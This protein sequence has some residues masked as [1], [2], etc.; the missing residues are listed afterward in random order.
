MYILC[1]LFDYTSKNIISCI[2]DLWCIAEPNVFFYSYG[3]IL[4]SFGLINGTLIQGLQ[5]DS[6][7][8]TTL[9]NLKDEKP[10]GKPDPDPNNGSVIPTSNKS[11]IKQQANIGSLSST[12]SRELAV[13]EGVQPTDISKSDNVSSIIASNI[14]NKADSNQQQSNSTGL[15]EDQWISLLSG[16]A[17]FGLLVSSFFYKSQIYAQ[18]S[19]TNLAITN[20]VFKSHYTNHMIIRIA[21]QLRLIEIQRN[22]PEMAEQVGS[23]HPLLQNVRIQIENLKAKQQQES[24]KKEDLEDLLTFMKSTNTLSNN[25]SQPNDNTSGNKSIDPLTSFENLITIMTNQTKTHAEVLKSLSSMERN[26][27][28]PSI[29]FI[30]NSYHIKY[31]YDI[32]LK[33]DNYKHM[34]I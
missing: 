22:W 2:D 5:S 8:N 14:D 28:S 31:F 13:E 15:S 27:K 30:R 32:K 18:E 12:S 17:G 23:I 4:I 16:G 9:Q 11:S 34:E 33:F 25:T 10:I 3:I 19:V 21:S 6:L 26:K 29:S 20:M 24:L 1:N 7:N